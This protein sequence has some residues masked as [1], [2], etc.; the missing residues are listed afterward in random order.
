MRDQLKA[1]LAET[2]AVDLPDTEAAEAFRIAWLGRKGPHEG[3]DGG[4]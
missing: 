4:V 2:S 1:L 3:F